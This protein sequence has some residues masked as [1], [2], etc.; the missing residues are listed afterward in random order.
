MIHF[1]LS[2]VL[3]TPNLFILKNSITPFAI[4]VKFR[5]LY[6]I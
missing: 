5:T 3:E 4:F 1:F 2:Y 6:I